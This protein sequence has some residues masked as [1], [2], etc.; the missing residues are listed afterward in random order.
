MSNALD[1]LIDKFSISSI[2]TIFNLLFNEDLFTKSLRFLIWGIG[3]GTC[4]AVT[5]KNSSKTK[6]YWLINR[7]LSY[8]LT[9]N[10]VTF[11]SAIATGYI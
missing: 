11:L 4:M 1:E 9:F 6:K 2:K 10:I 7:I 3:H 5:I 8:L